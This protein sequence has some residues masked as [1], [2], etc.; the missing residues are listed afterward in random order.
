MI[1]NAL[2]FLLSTVVILTFSNSSH[3]QCE[4][5]TVAS[6][7]GPGPYDVETLTESDGL[8]N[9]PGYL[10][11]RVY[12]P[13]NGTPPYP[14]IAISGPQAVAAWGPFYASHGI[15]AMVI[16]T[17]NRN[18]F[19]DSRANA[20]IDALRTLEEENTRESSPLEG[21]IDI[22]K[23]SVS[24]H[25]MGG[26]GAQLAAVL[27]NKVKAV[28]ALCPW[29]STFSTPSLDHSAPV[30]IFSG[31]NDN[32]ARPSQHANVHYN[33]TPNETN[34]ILYEINNGNHS[35]ANTP[36]GAQGN[37]GKLAISWLRL[38]LDAN[39]CYC[40]LM[41]EELLDSPA[42]ASSIETNLECSTLSINDV[43]TNELISGVY[44]N[45]T[46]SYVTV[47]SKFVNPKKYALYS[48][49]GEHLIAGTINS[50]KEQIDLSGLKPNVYL[51]KIDNQVVKISKTQ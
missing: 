1:K 22:D 2:T 43:S 20:L 28:V 41:N 11:A 16:G 39:D 7:T 44:P 14:S 19:P 32:V 51:L 36:N 42:T 45:P 13:T 6:I 8:R 12:Y 33:E 25:S 31:E 17:N 27:S 21:K 38:Q 10:E 30:L 26:G 34:K 23:F 29:L 9:G 5:V 48:I 40:S 49:L 4:D 3:A 24:G 15:I 47:E 50:G 35:V 37:V 46:N 18:E